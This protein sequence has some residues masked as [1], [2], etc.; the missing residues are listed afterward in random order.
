MRYV[1][2]TIAVITLI[3]RDAERKHLMLAAAGLA[4]YF[5]MSL[6]PALVLLAAGVAYLPLHDGLQ[7]L[8]SFLVHV[9]PPQGLSIIEN[10]LA[11]IGPHRSELVSFGIIATLWLASIGGK[12]VIASLDIA[13]GVSKPRP[14]WINRILACGLTLIVG[15]LMLLGVSLTLAGPTLRDILSTFVPVES[16]WP[17][18]W[19][20]LQWCLSAL[21]IFAAIELLYILAPNVD[22]VQRLTIPGALVAAGTWMALA[23][24]LG[25]YFHYFGTLKLH[26]FY[27][28][29][30]SPVAFMIWLY[31]GAGAFILGAQVNASLREHS[32]SEVT[33]KTE[34]QRP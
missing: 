27:G 14:I 10:I 28:I 24:G 26:R 21:F 6:F 22:P 12:G 30:A 34:T 20:Y 16:L 29:L 32:K 2:R 8:T 15:V 3:M 18:V 13:Y 4:Y 33:G 9:M 7:E 1:S 31:S 5:L 11:T 19:P 17:Q 25:F 23:W